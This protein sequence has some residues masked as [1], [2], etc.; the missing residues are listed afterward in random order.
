MFDAYSKRIKREILAI[1]KEKFNEDSDYIS[2]YGT[3]NSK[4]FFAETFA[5]LVNTKKPTTLAK[6]LEIY[7]R[8][9]L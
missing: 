2:K 8:E 5:N 9:N 4:E 1:Q 3:Y 6:S 7:I